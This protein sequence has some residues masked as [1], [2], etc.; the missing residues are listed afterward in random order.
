MYLIWHQDARNRLRDIANVT[1][2]AET[3]PVSCV[4][5]DVID[6]KEV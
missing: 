1:A 2:V 5:D 3:A 4:S 6:E